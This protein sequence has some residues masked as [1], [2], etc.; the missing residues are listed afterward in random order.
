[1][2]LT[3]G[4]TLAWRLSLILSLALTHALVLMFVF[5]LTL[6]WRFGLAVPLTFAAVLGR[7]DRRPMALVAGLCR[8]ARNTR[9]AKRKRHCDGQQRPSRASDEPILIDAES[10]HEDPIN[11]SGLSR[12]GHM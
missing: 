12:P 4:S 1:M 11:P 5:A 7:F 9:Q 10:S 3:Y 6:A 8:S 2:S